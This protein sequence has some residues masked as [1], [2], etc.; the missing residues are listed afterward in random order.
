[1]LY[2]PLGTSETSEIGCDL[3]P[4]LD[5]GRRRCTQTMH[6][7]F[8]SR[9]EQLGVTGY[10]HCGSDAW[11]HVHPTAGRLTP[12]EGLTLYA[13]PAIRPA[14]TNDL[15]SVIELAVIN[16]MFGANELDGL[17]DAFHGA[18]G[19]ASAAR[20]WFVSTTN[21]DR[22][23]AAAYLAPEPFADRFWNL[24]FI[25]VDPARHGQGVGTAL[26]THV[27]DV[28]RAAGEGQARVLIVET[29]STDPYTAARAF[30]RARGYHEEARIRDFYGPG[31]DKIV[32]W[33]KLTS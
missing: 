18:F 11:A 23:V 17:I 26:L 16:N 1:M 25:A 7:R 28:L 6:T 12:M 22:V 3:V 15:V 10:L 30:Y 19:D 9:R 2:W 4:R 32:F 27:E 29:S 21:D 5:V 20:R 8:V 13:A 14:T 33:K 24:Y 31:D